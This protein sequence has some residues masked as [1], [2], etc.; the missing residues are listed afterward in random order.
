MSVVKIE[1]FEKVTLFTINRPEKHNAICKETALALQQG[2][3]EFDLSDQRVAV[4]TGAGEKAFSAGADV[5]NLPE[6]W[7]C[8]PTVGIQTEKPIIAA[9]A[10][11]VVGGSMVLHMMCDLAIA[12]DNTRFSYPEAKLGFTGG[13][14]AGLAARIPHKVAMDVILCGEILDAQRAYEVGLVNQVVPLGQQVEIALEKAQK[15]SK[16]S[17]LVLK[18]LKRFI[19]R[20][21]LPQGPSELM[22][23]TIRELN[24]VRESDD[25]K[26]GVQAF[27]EKREPVY[28]GK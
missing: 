12:A 3:E 27:R 20:D 15:L 22:A 25:Q 6:L 13:M 28:S 21:V 24:V 10:G 5:T 26:E 2:F 14:I 16:A 8:I 9:T 4:I 19:T 1:Q 7:R 23:R 17:P 18:T 11:W